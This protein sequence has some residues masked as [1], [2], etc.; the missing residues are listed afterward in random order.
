MGSLSVTSIYLGKSVVCAYSLSH[1]VVGIVTMSNIYHCRYV[2]ASRQRS[3]PMYMDVHGL[4]LQI[5]WWCCLLCWVLLGRGHYISFRFLIWPSFQG[6]R[7]QS[8]SSAL[9]FDNDGTF[10]IA[11]Y[12][13]AQTS[14]TCTPGWPLLRD[15]FRVSYQSSFGHQGAICENTKSVITPIIMVAA[16][17]YF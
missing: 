9:P 13:W 10:C 16:S 3:L 11:W 6:H 8:A 1:P 4:V 7:G 12:Y 15:R 5:Q 17:W 2:M 14:Y